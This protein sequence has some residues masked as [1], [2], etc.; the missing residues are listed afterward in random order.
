MSLEALTE[1][2]EVAAAS[3]R[4]I[5]YTMAP[6]VMT[7]IG[8]VGFRMLWLC[9]IFKKIH[10]FEMLM[11]VYPVS[12]IFTAAMVVSAYFILRKKRGL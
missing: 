11:L 4:S 1:T 7:I 6:A 5:G 10:T 8:T 12:W 9:T 2:Y 3:L